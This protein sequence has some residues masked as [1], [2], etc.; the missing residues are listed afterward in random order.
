MNRANMWGAAED[1]CQICGVMIGGPRTGVMEGDYYEDGTLRSTEGYSIETRDGQYL[2]LCEDCL[3]MTVNQ[4]F[5]DLH[6]RKVKAE[7]Q[8]M[9]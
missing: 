1:N 6:Q 2:T 5:L 8:G 7:E 3:R 4:Q 9:I